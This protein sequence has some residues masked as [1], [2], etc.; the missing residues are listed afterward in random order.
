MKTVFLHIG[1]EKTGTSYLHTLMVRGRQRI[2]EHDILFP[3]GTPRH[4]RRMQKGLV[5]AGNGYTLAS[6]IRQNSFVDISGI[7]NRWA[8]RN[9]NSKC[10]GVLVTS[11][12]LLPALSGAESVSGLIKAFHNVGFA[13]VRFLLILRDP[14]DQCLSLYKHRAK[15][16]TAG[17][18]AAWCA[19]GYHVPA[20]LAGFRRQAEALGAEVTVQPYSRTPGKLESLFFEDWLGVP[21]P[22]V[23]V[24]K[25]VNISLTLSELALLRQVAQMRPALVEPLYEALNGLDPKNKVQGAALEAYARAV[26]TNAVAQH[27]EEWAAWNRY[28]P[29]DA[30]LTIPAP[31]D[32]LPSPPAEVGFS[33]AQMAV[34]ADLLGRSA[35]PRFI[36]RLA[37]RQ[38]LRPALGRAKRFVWRPAQ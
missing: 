33:E 9:I 6:S 24:P 15:R 27:A 19:S 20:Q 11:E 16:G 12:L 5:S 4:E 26:V 25:T 14:V 36:A 37:W 23:C 32:Q 17:D 28:L 30:Q 1:L 2:L 18:I 10:S 34:L 35:T 7:I 13:E 31:V 29:A 38:H 3:K 22:Q 21:V 8:D